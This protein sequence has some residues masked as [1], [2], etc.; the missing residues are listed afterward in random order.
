[1]LVPGQGRIEVFL[2]NESLKRIAKSLESTPAQ[3]IL[4]WEVHRGTS[5]IPKTE[6]EN[7]MKANI[8]VRA[9]SN[10]STSNQS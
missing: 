4:A 2:E 8:T 1:M 7:R 10:N 9:I 5:T 6:N 3:V